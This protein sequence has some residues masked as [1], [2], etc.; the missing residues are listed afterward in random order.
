MIKLVNPFRESICP[1]CNRPYFPGNCAIEATLAFDGYSPGD[2][3]REARPGFFAR[4]F[5]IPLTGPKYT[6]TRA[7]RLCPNCSYHLPPND[8][9]ESYTIAIVGDGS[10][11]KSHYIA[12]C[13]N[14]LRQSQALQVIGCNQIIAHG[15]TDNLYY[16]NYYVPI[17][18]NKQKVPLSQTG[19]EPEPLI[20]ELVFPNKRIH[21][22][23]YDSS[24]EDIVDQQQMVQF[25]HYVLDASAIIFLADP[26]TMPGIVRTLPSHI[27]L[28]APRQLNTHQVLDR[29]IATF[30]QNQ[31]GNINRNVTIPIA[32][33]ISKSDLL[34]FAERSAFPPLY[35]SENVLPNRLD[36]PKFEF[37]SNEIQNLIRRVGDKN[38]LNSSAAFDTVSF[39]AV[40]ATGWTEDT[41]GQFPAIEPI[42][43]LDPLLWVMWKLGIINAD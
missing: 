32:I 19:I 18:I 28:Q 23:F 35:L 25:S 9:V 10:S 26:M 36:L 37:I 27:Q 3:L 14:Q 21:L 7:V 13:I 42:R 15:T 30:K 41:N 1:K 34:Q 39:F 16:N 4:P 12:S 24:G 29:V 31:G 11:G 2:K 8:Y 17:Y 22:H 20:Y 33:T 5:M 40:S 43:C 6:R 38:L